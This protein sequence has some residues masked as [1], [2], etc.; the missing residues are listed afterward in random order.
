MSE[1]TPSTPEP[2]TPAETP[3]DSA[4]F[5][6]SV[7]AWLAVMLVGTVCVIHL[8]AVAAQVYSSLKTGTLPDW[9]GTLVGEPLY[10]MGMTALGFYLGQKSKGA[11]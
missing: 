10:S 5:G 8:T 6:V 7:R 4:V 3:G 11:S 1:S 2:A 9:S